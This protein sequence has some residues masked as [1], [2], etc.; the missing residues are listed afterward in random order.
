[1]TGQYTK[2]RVQSHAVM[3]HATIQ[4]ETAAG[5]IVHGPEGVRAAQVAA[6]CLV[7]PHVG[8]RVLV[9]RAGA[10]CYVL[11]ILSRESRDRELRVNG[12][13][14]VSAKRLRLSGDEDVALKGGHK[15]GLHGHRIALTSDETAVCG[16]RVEVTADEGR[17]QFRKVQL[18]ASSLETCADRIGQFARTVIRRVEEVETTQ[19]GNLVQN[20]RESLISRSKRTS[21]TARKDVHVDGERIHMG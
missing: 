9:T 3:E 13:L 21:M 14:A 12:E 15:V 7:A 11:T 17:A 20:I 4:A 5:W 16:R 8:D 2:D 1:M 19:I 6:G 10:E 18:V